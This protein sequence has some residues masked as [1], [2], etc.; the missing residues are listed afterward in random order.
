M[1]KIEKL[2]EIRLY[3]RNFWEGLLGVLLTPIGG[4]LQT[5]AELAA[6]LTA[7]LAVNGLDGLINLFGKRNVQYK[8]F[9]EGLLGTL[10]TPIGGAL[11]T[12]A[13]LLAQI[14]AGLAING[15][16]GLIG[17][18][19]GRTAAE[20][21]RIWDLITSIAGEYYDN[22]LAPVVTEASQSLA[23]MAAQLLAG[24]AEGGL[25]ALTSLLSG[26]LG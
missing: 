9:W 24:V 17:L 16:D 23:L 25:P 4:A 14:T 18:F 26:L 11:Q 13:E 20:Y 8:N 1:I 2:S 19:G 12:S 10:L 5:T 22:V 21:T 6:Q 15:L 7:G 3:D